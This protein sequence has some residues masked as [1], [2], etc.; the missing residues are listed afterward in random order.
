MT[1][2]KPLRTSG[3]VAHSEGVPG[4]V[5]GLSASPALQAGILLLGRLQ[6]VVTAQP[7]EVRGQ[8]KERGVREREESER[9]RGH[10]EGGV[11]EREES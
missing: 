10:R 3:Q 11:I 2:W 6:H 1:V 9:G 4:W 8:G 5:A 7:L